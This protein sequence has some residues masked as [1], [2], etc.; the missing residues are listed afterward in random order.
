MDTNFAGEAHNLRADSVNLHDA[1]AVAQVALRRMTSTQKTPD[2]GRHSKHL[3]CFTYSQNLVVQPVLT[4][5]YTAKGRL[6]HCVRAVNLNT[7][8]SFLVL[9]SHFPEMCV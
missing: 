5:C 3:F 8:L 6:S 1:C 2:K 4:V 9:P 7:V